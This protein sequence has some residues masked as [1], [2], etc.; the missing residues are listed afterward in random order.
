MLAGHSGTTL[1]PT[2]VTGTRVTFG[3]LA[4]HAPR[5]LPGG[6]FEI[7]IIVKACMGWH[8]TRF[9]GRISSAFFDNRAV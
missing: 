6:L 9:R 2:N 5:V 7:G 1:P 4:G 3:R 8:V